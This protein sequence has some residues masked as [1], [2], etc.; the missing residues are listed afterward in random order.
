[1][2][3]F[4]KVMSGAFVIGVIRSP[5]GLL[6]PIRRMALKLL[7]GVVQAHLFTVRGTPFASGPP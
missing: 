1:M 5:A 3:W 7:T 2:R 4:G 6:T